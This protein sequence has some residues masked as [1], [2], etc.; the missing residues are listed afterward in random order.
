MV[1][2][3]FVL[4]VVGHWWMVWLAPVS[5]IL[6]G[7]DDGGARYRRDLFESSLKRSAEVK[8]A[9][10]LIPGHGG[11]LDRLD[12]ILFAAPVYYAVVVLAS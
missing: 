8:D 11:V 7:G 3:M 6:L 4:A 10:S 2:G 1:A 9:S 5:R 12:G